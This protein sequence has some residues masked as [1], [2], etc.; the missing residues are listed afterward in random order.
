MTLHI[1]T[2]VRTSRSTAV[3]DAI[4]AGAGPGKLRI[5]SGTQPANAN[6]TATGTLLLEFT[7]DDPCGTVTSG[8]LTFAINPA[9]DIADDALA[10]ATAGWGRFL[11]SADNPVIDGAI[12]SEITLTDLTLDTGQT[13]TFA[14]ATLTE[15]V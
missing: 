12:G 6:A 4:D 2:A 1:A 7:L 8:V 3:L 9:I 10:T 5:Y 11:D 13:V 15:A 14:A